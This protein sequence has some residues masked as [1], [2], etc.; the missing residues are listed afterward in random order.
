M[1]DLVWC[2]VP[3]VDIKLGNAWK[4]LYKIVEKLCEVNY[5]IVEIVKKR[6]PRVVHAN[7]I[8]NFVERE[9]IVERVTLVTEEDDFEISKAEAVPIWADG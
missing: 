4:G 2:R 6:K 9:E 8:N 3:G 7:T 5:R 1:N